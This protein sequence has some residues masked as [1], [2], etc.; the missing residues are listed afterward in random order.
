MAS[1]SPV[2]EEVELVIGNRTDELPRVIAVLDDLVRRH[3]LPDA[4]LDMHVAL[5][6]VL[7]NIVKYAY[8][9]AASHDIRVRLKVSEGRLEAAVEDDGWPFDPLQARPQD[10]NVPLAERRPGGLGIDV[11]KRLMSHLSYVRTDGRNRVTL[12]RRLDR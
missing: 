12:I 2:L 9:D 10:R 8:P 4:A 3:R 5:D 7:S 11:V 6:E 1:E